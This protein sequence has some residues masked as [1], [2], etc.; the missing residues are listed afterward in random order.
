MTTTPLRGTVGTWP[1][2]VLMA[3][4]N[5]RESTLRALDSL[6]AQKGLPRGVSIGVHLVD[7]GSSDGTADAV[8]ATFPGTD[9]VTVG[10]D[11]YW[12]T[13]MAIA[14]QRAP[15][16]SHV[17][18]LNDDVELH[19]HA[20]ATLLRTADP[21]RHP[22]VVVG[23]TRS[24]VAPRTTYSGYRM[25][26]TGGLRP[27]SAVRLEPDADG[28]R[29]CDTGNGNI[30]LVT[31]AARR[32]LGDIDRVFPHRLGDLDYGL[33]ARRAGIP[34]LLAA[35]YLGVCDQNPAR[36]PGTSAEPGIGPGL[37]LRRLASVREQPP[38]PW[39]HYCRRHLGIWAP[40][41]FCSPYVRA[42]SRSLIRSPR[43]A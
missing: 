2:T 4:H 17:L 20:V 14:A 41:I 19:P 37:A 30:V 21:L 25:T 22:V 7:A 26:R 39:W 16:D 36:A 42:L 28:P 34:V 9:V 6:Q 27:P 8:R 5:R 11:V 40:L 32:V 33:R 24:R 15:A 12:G 31:A 43:R 29:S 3:C 1:L 18:W 10:P 35:G 13:G 38:G 23:A